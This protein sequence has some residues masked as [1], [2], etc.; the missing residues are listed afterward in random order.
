MTSAINRPRSTALVAAILTM[1]G[2]A[3]AFCRP[4]NDLQDLVGARANDQALRSRGYRPSGGNYNGGANWVYWWNPNTRVCAGIVTA[5]GRYNQI[6]QFDPGRCG[7]R[8]DNGYND[9]SGPGGGYGGGGYNSVQR[10]RVDTAGKGNFNGFGRNFRVTRG[11]VDTT[12]GRPLVALSG[13][14][15]FK[16]NFYGSVDGGNRDFTMRI[17]STDQ[18]NADGTIMFRLNSD[19]NEVEMINLKGRAFNGGPFSGYFSR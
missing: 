1:F 13:D 18:G 16:V 6:D 19:R 3:A 11:W 8:P 10:I 15:N 12:G 9:G 4:P 14:R 17:R 2:A 7:N 5:N